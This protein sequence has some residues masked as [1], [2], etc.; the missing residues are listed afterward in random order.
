MRLNNLRLKF[1]VYFK[2]PKIM[3]WNL[4]EF[5]LKV[6]LDSQLL[7]VNFWKIDRCQK[8]NFY[9]PLHSQ[10]LKK[11]V[12]LILTFNNP[13]TTEWKWRKNMLGQKLTCQL[14]DHWSTVLGISKQKTRQLIDQFLVNNWR[15]DG[16][17][18]PK[19]QIEWL[20]KCSF[21]ILFS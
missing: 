9:T 4:T 20:C 14:I 19:D 8:S 12:C 13:N 7:L 2:I 21:T 11:T 15:K 10:L 1:C 16:Q 6:H 18:W 17:F 3:S 5:W